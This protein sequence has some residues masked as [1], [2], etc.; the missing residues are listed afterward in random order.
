MDNPASTG[1]RRCNMAITF[2]QA[3][4]QDAQAVHAVANA[5]SHATLMAN[6]VNAARL[7]QEG[8]LL[9]PLA[10]ASD[11]EPNYRERIEASQ[12]FYVAEVDSV[13][14]GFMM[15]YTFER[16]S[17]LVHK[18]P[19]DIA[20]LDYY[21]IHM[22]MRP[23]VIYIAQVAVLPAYRGRQVSVALKNYV[24]DTV[25]GVDHPAA[26]G[27]IAQHPLWNRASSFASA[28]SGFSPLFVRDKAIPNEPDQQRLSAT[29]IRTFPCRRKLAAPIVG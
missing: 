25:D 6:G 5:V 11:K 2:R 9:Y 4:S 20:T 10:A 23:E 1:H 12:Y 17:K 15:A 7:S 24:F 13:V 19:N 3:L 22:R 21:L 26:I 16:M 28:A 14:I 29:F 27:E 8:F 18:T